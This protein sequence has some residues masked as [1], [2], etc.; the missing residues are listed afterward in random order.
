MSAANQPGYRDKAGEQVGGSPGGAGGS[1]GQSG[2][3]AVCGSASCLSPGAE[4]EPGNRRQCPR[5]R[6][7]PTMGQRA[8]PSAP[9]HPPAGHQPR[10]RPRW[11]G[12]KGLGG[13]NGQEAE[14]R[15]P[16]GQ[17][18]GR[19]QLAQALSG[20]TCP[21]ERGSRLG[22]AGT[23]THQALSRLSRQSRAKGKGQRSRFRVQAAEKPKQSRA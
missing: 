3:S 14:G 5:P 6:T 1:P 18:V 4:K 7:A 11:E 12:R 23:T 10:I 16:A 8:P 2:H 13:H 22:P 9:G 21:G 19:R 20:T 17:S 15:V